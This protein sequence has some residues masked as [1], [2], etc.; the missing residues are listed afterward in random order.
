M[1]STR[2]MTPAQR[3]RRVCELQ[4]VIDALRELPV[5]T[6]CAECVH[7][8][9]EQGYCHAWASPVPLEAQADGCAKWDEGVPF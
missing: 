4:N 5:V 3:D 6:P 7:F 8:D 2:L 9:A 1:H